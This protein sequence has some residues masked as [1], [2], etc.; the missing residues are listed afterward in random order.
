MN[1]QTPKTNWTPVDGVRDTDINR[2]EGNI[3][4]LYNQHARNAITLYVSPAPTGSNTTGD[5]TSAKPYATIQ[6]ALNVL[7]R[8][9]NGQT[10]TIRI[11][12]GTYNEDVVIADFNGYLNITGSYEA[13][14]T[15]SSL[16]VRASVCNISAISLRVNTGIT[17]T[18]NATLLSGSKITIPG[19]TTGLTVSRGSTCVITAAL[20]IYGVTTAGVSATNA[21]RVYLL[22]FVISD[23]AIA[24]ES[25]QGSVISYGNTNMTVTTAA[26]VTRTG[27]RIYSGAQSNVPAV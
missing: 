2:I 13:A 18:Y 26:F 25:Q 9:S 19:G 16:T 3:D 11:A 4:Y 1:W 6:H 27:G 21:S 12:A 20:S 8:S 10:V 7:P 15:I 5:G 22:S 24:L 17:V 14:V 23:A